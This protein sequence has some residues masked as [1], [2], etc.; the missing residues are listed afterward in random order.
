[1]TQLG[2]LAS[3]EVGSDSKHALCIVH[4]AVAT[5][6]HVVLFRNLASRPLGKASGVLYASG[7]CEAQAVSVPKEGRSLGLRP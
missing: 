5:D 3:V 6:H 7:R 4:Y 1:M 2:V